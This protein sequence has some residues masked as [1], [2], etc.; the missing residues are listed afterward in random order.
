M[1]KFIT[2]TT[3]EWIKWLKFEK[4]VSNNTLN[5]Y[6][7][8]LFSF[9]RFINNYENRKIDI[10]LIKLIG[11]KQIRGWFYSRIKKN[12]TPRSNARALSSVKSY[13]YFLIKNG[14]IS[15]SR[16]LSLK[17]PKYQDSIPRPLSK[18][19][20]EKLFC[21]DRSKLISWDVR[22]NQSIFLLMWGYG[23]RIGEV[24]DIKYKQLK[25]NEFLIIISKGNKERS[26]PMLP[27]LKQYIMQMLEEMPF[28]IDDEDYIFLGKRGKK[29]NPRI[30]QKELSRIRKQNFLP[31]KTTPHSLRHTFATQ[32]LDNKVDL[33][34]I[35]EL[36]GHESLS[37]TQ[38]YTAIDISKIRETIENHHPRGKK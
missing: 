24:L 10:D 23:L 1:N 22:R 26:I 31:E 21:L 20:L 18:E 19:Q 17:A 7:I 2:Q 38:K 13:I 36:L 32:L 34:V 15:S 4:R 6:K 11:E 14:I 25:Y 16:I 12:I 35:Q 29:L 9:L 33:R 5:S 37:T 3:N 27:E 28:S 30:I 8:D